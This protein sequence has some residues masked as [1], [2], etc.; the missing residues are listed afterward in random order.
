MRPLEHPVIR[1]LVTL[2][3]RYAI[4]HLVLC[5]GSRNAPLLHALSHGIE[6][7]T[8]YSIVDERSAGFYALGVAIATHSPV[9]VCCTSGTAL[10]NLYPA[11]AEAYY[12]GIPLIVISA[13]RPEIWIGQ[14][15]GQTLP[16]PEIFGSLVRKAIHIPEPHTAEERWYSNR[17][18]NEALLATQY[19]LPGPV[20]INIPLADPSISL[21]ETPM[22][23]EE[24][25]ENVRGATPCGM[26]P[27]RYIEL[28]RSLR[29]DPT[30]LTDLIQRLPRFRRK[31]ILLGQETWDIL[32]AAKP[33]PQVLRK[34]FFCLGE[35]LCNREVSLCSFDALLASLTEEEKEEL[36]PDLLIT[37]GGH[38][39]S[40]KMKQYLR[41]HPPREHWHISLDPSVV[42]LFHTLTDLIIAP[43]EDFLEALSESISREKLS[44]YAE[45]WQKRVEQ[46]PAPQMYYNSLGVVGSLIAHL[47]SEPFVLHLANSSAVRYAELFPKPH[48]IVT[49]CNR[50]TSGIE[51]SLSTALGFA[52]V[53][54]AELQIIVIGDLSFFYDLN[55]LAIQ[56]IGKHV[57]VLLLNNKRGSI[58]QSLPTL[59]MDRLSQKYIT[60][61][62]HSEA[63]GWVESSGWDYYSV[64][65]S[66]E[67]QETMPLWLASGEYPK[68]LEV[69]VEADRE[70]A[71][72]KKIFQ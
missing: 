15:A 60:A 63:K 58:F 12:Q 9:A 27:G 52:S 47:P 51:G 13:D 2:L 66:E 35:S 70:I 11:V 62:H 17:L 25:A 14:M 45:V 65:G 28:H 23:E 4:R 31:M 64:K 40:N 43:P 30:L 61:E 1:E 26:L 8:C 57:R 19:P 69:F 20:H 36:Q 55:A 16:Q 6:G 5:P 67:L 38:I 49:L 44:L 22:E 53:R 71:E 56:D 3:D 42:D 41:T 21:A 39:V 33:F 68:L 34:H 46:L 10:A 7:A 50:G 29:L 24:R 18:L 59:E 54:T 72:L 37:M 32:E 48:P